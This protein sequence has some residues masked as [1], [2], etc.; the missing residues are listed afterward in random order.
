MSTPALSPFFV[1]Q[2]SWLRHCAAACT[3]ELLAEFLGDVRARLALVRARVRE[4]DETMARNAVKRIAGQGR[5]EA[6]RAVP[7]EQ[8][9]AYLGARA[10]RAQACRELKVLVPAERTARVLREQLLQGPRPAG[11]RR[12]A[13]HWPRQVLAERLSAWLLESA[14]GRRQVV[15]FGARRTE[16]ANVEHEAATAQELLRAHPALF[17]SMPSS[18][19]EGAAQPGHLPQAPRSVEVSPR[20][21][22]LKLAAACELSRDEDTLL[23]QAL[24]ISPGRPR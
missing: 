1:E 19:A 3:P 2:A 11:A 18:G 24:G 7:M 21:L 15:R 17:G 5:R 16:L 12:A 14:H 22:Y 6:L 10:I 13:E 20:A 23:R 8:L 4:A 9:G